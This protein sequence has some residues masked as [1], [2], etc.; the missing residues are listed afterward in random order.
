MKAVVSLQSK[1][2]REEQS[3]K[4]MQ[5]LKDEYGLFNDKKSYDADEPE[6]M[7]MPDNYDPDSMED[8]GYGITG[9]E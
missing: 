4:E 6:Y 9:D 2:E 7:P 1:S 3:K 8:F 5:R